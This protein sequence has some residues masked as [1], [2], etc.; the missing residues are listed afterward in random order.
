MI[1]FHL[2]RSG[3]PAYLQ[4]VQQVRQAIRLGMLRPGDQLPTV[5]EVVGSLAINP[6][7]VLK[8][9]RELDLEGLVEGRRGQGT[10]VSSGQPPQPPADLKAVRS[11][12]ERWIAAAHAAGLDDESIAALLADTLRASEKVA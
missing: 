4:L 9:Y 2:E 5:K 3:V 1:Q 10:F 7:T 11:G 12:L 6:N 8:A